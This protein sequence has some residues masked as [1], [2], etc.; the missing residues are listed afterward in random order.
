MQ[1]KKQRK[2]EKKEKKEGGGSWK[3][4]QKKRKKNALWITVVIHGAFGPFRCIYN[5]L[6]RIINYILIYFILN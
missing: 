6:F 2:F 5:N 3:K 4:I 1:Q